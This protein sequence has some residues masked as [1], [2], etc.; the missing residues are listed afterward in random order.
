[1]K[2]I[3]RKKYI[4]LGLKISYYRKI[5]GMT[6]EKLAEAIEKDPS[7]IGQIEAPNVCKAISLDTLF[8]ISTILNVPSSKFLDFEDDI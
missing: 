5:R 8:D 1:M 6:Q 7:Y 2:E 3:Y 4:N